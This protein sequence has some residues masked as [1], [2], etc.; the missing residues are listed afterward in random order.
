AG[1]AVELNHAEVENGAVLATFDAAH[2]NDHIKGLPGTEAIKQARGLLRGNGVAQGIE[3][4]EITLLQQPGL[5]AGGDGNLS[6]GGQLVAQMRGKHAATTKL[7]A[8]KQHSGRFEH[9]RHPYLTTT[10]VAE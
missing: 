10:V 5:K 7:G 6:P 4:P 9:L 1:A 2:F 8:H 3:Q